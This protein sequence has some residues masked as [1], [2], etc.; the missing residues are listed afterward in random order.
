MNEPDEYY[1]ERAQ[2]FRRI[3]AQVVRI[4]PWLEVGE[5]L[6][7]FNAITEGYCVHCGHII[8]AEGQC[9]CNNDE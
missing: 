7:V 9:H 1:R 5:R 4:L 2:D 3:T 8:P 6:F